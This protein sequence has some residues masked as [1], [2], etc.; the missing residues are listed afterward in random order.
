MFL[1]KLIFVQTWCIIFLCK[2]LVLW[3]LH[4]SF[5]LFVLFLHSSFWLIVLAISSTFTCFESTCHL[6][7]TIPLQW[8]PWRRWCLWSIYKN[9]PNK[10]CPTISVFNNSVT[11]FPVV[12]FNSITSFFSFGNTE[13]LYKTSYLHPH[14]VT[15]FLAFLF[16]NCA[17]SFFSPSLS[18]SL[19]SSHYGQACAFTLLPLS[20]TKH[21]SSCLPICSAIISKKKMKSSIRY[22]T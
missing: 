12:I 13:Y 11:S 6:D 7:H 22:I 10:K 14:R 3:I 9:K 19:S 21:L 5:C 2:S 18:V 17:Y 16:G 15:L 1:S 4:S 8:Q 20:F